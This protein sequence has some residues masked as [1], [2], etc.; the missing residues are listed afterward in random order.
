MLNCHKTSLLVLT[1]QAIITDLFQI[2]SGRFFSQTWFVLWDFYLIS[3]PVAGT[4]KP[5]RMERKMSAE[6]ILYEYNHELKYDSSYITLDV[7][8][9]S[10][11][12]DL[13]LYL[14]LLNNG[15]LTS[16]I[17]SCQSSI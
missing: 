8:I 14:F 4:G 1:V 16:I 5:V 6:K 15:F 10:Q 13:L 12:D 17:N 7:H 9:Y 3:F 2:K 11:K